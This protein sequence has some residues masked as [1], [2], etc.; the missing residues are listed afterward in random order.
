MLI[1]YFKDKPDNHEMTIETYINE[2]IQDYI[3]VY[4]K[5]KKEALKALK[6]S[7]NDSIKDL[8]KLL[9]RV[10]STN[11]VFCGGSYYSPKQK[12]II[13]AIV[14]YNENFKAVTLSFEDGGKKYNAVKIMQELFGE[15]AGGKAGIAGTPRGIEFTFGDTKKV[16][17][18]LEVQS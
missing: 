8:E 10:F 6:D 17:E 7:I 12:K 3:I 18:R 14:S 5:T 9:E 15:G 4:G 13:P 2:A 11:R 1:K 16:I